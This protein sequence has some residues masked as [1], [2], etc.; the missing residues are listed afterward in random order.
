M[1]S[2]TRRTHQRIFIAD[3]IVITIGEIERGQVR[4]CIECPRHIPIAR[5]EQL[6]ADEAQEIEEAAR[7]GRS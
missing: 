1:L 5:E 7:G 6:L 2:L 3:N 4:V